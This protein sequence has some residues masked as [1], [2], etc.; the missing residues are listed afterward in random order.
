MADYI[1]KIVLKGRLGNAPDIRYLPSGDMVANFSVATK[2]GQNVEW[3][4]ITAF[5]DL[6]ERAQKDLEK[7]DLVYVEGK[8]RTRD[9][10]SAEDKVAQRKPRKIRE[11]IADAVHLVEKSKKNGVQSE[12][13]P[14]ADGDDLPEQS[15]DQSASGIPSYI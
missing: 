14:P 8:I 10:L 12:D 1:N 13:A 7:G 11:I 6:A 2:D 4:P 15:T 5:K 9:Y 3:H